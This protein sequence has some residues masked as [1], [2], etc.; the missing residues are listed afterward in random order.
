L[1]LSLFVG[2]VIVTAA[3]NL[4]LIGGTLNLIATVVGL[5]LLVQL[6]LSRSTT[7]PDQAS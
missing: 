1:V 5:G 3:V 7:P 6:W 4:P 2:L